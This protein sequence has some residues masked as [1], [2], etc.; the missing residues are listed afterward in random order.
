[1]LENSL[2]RND[3]ERSLRRA[4][5]SP[6]I[7]D[8]TVTLLRDGPKVFASWLEDIGNARRFILFE[9][10]IFRS[11]RI[12]HKIAEALCKRAQDGLEVYVLF[13]WLGSLGTSRSLWVKMQRA[14]VR[15]RAFGSFHLTDPLRLLTRNHRKVMCVDGNI[16]HVGGLCVGD[17]WAGNPDR[18]LAPW[19]D[20][21]V[22][23]E[24]PAALQLCQAFD[25]TWSEAGSPLPDRIRFAE[26]VSAS[27]PDFPPSERPSEDT[28]CCQV[29]VRVISGLPGRSRIYRLTQVLLTNATSRIFITDAYFLTPPL[30]Y[31]ALTSAARDGVD[32]RVLVPGRSDI[33]W[34]AWASRAGYV[35]LLQAG[36]RIFE[37]QGPMLHAK[38]TVVDGRYCRVGSSNL[39][40]ASLLTNWELDVVIEDPTFGQAAEQMFLSDLTQTRELQL[41]KRRVRAV[42]SPK[43]DQTA[44]APVAGRARAAVVQAGAAVLGV[45]L[46]RRYERSPFSVA[47]VAALV[48]LG[49][50][51]FGLLFPQLFGL[52][53]SALCVWFGV[54]ALLRGL[55]DF[56]TTRRSKKKRRSPTS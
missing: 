18:G 36:V 44:A 53:L 7:A 37:W 1:M 49:L 19:R 35:G 39:N 15:V 13:D 42:G 33:P 10:Y 26:P 47:I 45:A 50:G 56:H 25:E 43:T 24:G 22:R 32:V 2:L 28:P 21:A 14:G 51:A 27:G 4:G 38:T 23:F 52:G 12:G 11:D 40:L 54:G 29:P 17:P 6:S 55:A 3:P 16:G 5:D 46:R 20:T 34:I 9:N 8:N 31:E 30:M 48:L 41:R